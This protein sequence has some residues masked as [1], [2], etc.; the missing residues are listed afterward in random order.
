MNRTSHNTFRLDE[1]PEY[2]SPTILEKLAVLVD[3]YMCKKAVISNIKV[4]L[5]S[6]LR[7]INVTELCLLL[8][9]A[10]IMHLTER[11]A[12]VSKEMLFVYMGAD[13]GLALLVDHPL[14]HSS[15]ATT[16]VCNPF[17]YA[18]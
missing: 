15:T 7:N 1:I 13:A 5:T 6:K 14:I 17:P 10:Y 16:L 9:L 11:F 4:W 2:L 12:A 8:L 18:S 3:R